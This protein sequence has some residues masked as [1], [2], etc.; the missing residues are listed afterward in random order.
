MPS[1]PPAS[2]MRS[3]ANVQ[4]PA[5]SSV[6]NRRVRVP[7]FMP[8]VAWVRYGTLCNRTLSARFTAAFANLAKLPG[9]CA[10]LAAACA[11]RSGVR[12]GHCGFDM[13]RAHGHVVVREAF[14]VILDDVHI[15]AGLVAVAGCVGFQRGSVA[16]AF[17]LRDGFAKCQLAAVERMRAACA[18]AACRTAAEHLS[19]C[20]V[21][22]QFQPG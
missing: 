21:D 16:G 19:G 1:G 5:N 17:G 14:A 9:G 10:A 2:A 22:A 13:A 3:G 7:D 11:G 8:A 4:M 20:R 12:P 6:V 15:H 18:L